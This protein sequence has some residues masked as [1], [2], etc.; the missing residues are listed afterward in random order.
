[1]PAGWKQCRL[2]EVLTLQRGFDITKKEQKPGAIPV[3][4]SSGIQSYHNRAKVKGP[5]VIIGRKGSLGT[6]FYV[7][8]DYWPH[9]TT[10]WVKDFHG[11]SPRFMYYFL[12]TLNL[13]QYDVGAANPSLNRN[14][15][16]L[17][18]VSWPPL[19][20]QRQIADILSAYDDL[21]E[22]NTR[23]IAILEELTHTLYH[24][25]FVQFRFPGHERVKLV[26]S[27]LGM[28]PQGWEIKAI[29]EVV[30][31]LG[32]GTPSTKVPAYWDDGDITWYSPTDL[33]SSG[34]IFVS[35]S[36]R[37]ITPLGL[38]ESSARLFP[39][40]SVLLTSR[41]TIGV[42]AINTKPA[43]TNQGFIICIPNDILSPYQLYHWLDVTR[44]TILRLASGTTF[45]EINRSTFKQIPVL[46]PPEHLS[47]QFNEC[48]HPIYKHIEN[49]VARNANL[50]H[51]RDLL[52][53]KLMTG[54]LDVAGWVEG[55]RVTASVRSAASWQERTMEPIAQEELVWNS[56]WE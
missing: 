9:D 6:T 39:A 13:A 54:E 56:L 37:K 52:L 23:R 33:T 47:R 8:G 21:I 45:K 3:I 28:V 36:A 7:E 24:E 11:N 22:N 26:A 27:E 19:P 14:H 16:H 42:V 51:T 44:E 38:K 35:D 20:I 48:V 41:A 32:G 50:R 5:G 17:L 10:L 18:P 30:Q 1:M 2:G 40:Y 4:S 46:L 43:C 49:L 15:V 34:T 53:P 12:G 55:E 31:I 29:G 25:W